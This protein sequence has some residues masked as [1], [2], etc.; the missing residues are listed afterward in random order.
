MNVPA[1]DFTVQGSNKS[2]PEKLS[3]SIP[4]RIERSSSNAMRLHLPA[5]LVVLAEGEARS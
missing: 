2:V 4:A 5:S 3:A 1:C